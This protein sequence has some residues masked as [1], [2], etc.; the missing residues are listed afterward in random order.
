MGSLQDH[1]WGSVG[2]RPRSDEDEELSGWET[3]HL[4]QAG[5]SDS[6]ESELALT[7]TETER[8]RRLR[9]EQL[10]RKRP[11]GFARWPDA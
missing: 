3:A 10:A 1:R 5:S 11:P 9:R 2:I 4:V 6:H 8:E 7:K